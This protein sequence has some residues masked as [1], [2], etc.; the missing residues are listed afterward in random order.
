MASTIFF[1]PMRLRAVANLV[2]MGL[3]DCGTEPVADCPGVRSPAADATAQPA[4]PAR[5]N[6]TAMTAG[7]FHEK[8]GGAAGTRSDPYAPVARGRAGG[9]PAGRAG[10]GAGAGLG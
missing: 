9:R 4:S 1:W 8:R 2:S 5:A 7:A 10:A 6:T 3:P